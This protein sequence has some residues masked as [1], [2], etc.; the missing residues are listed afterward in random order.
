[1]LIRRK[2]SWEIPEHRASGEDLFRNRRR[3]VQAAAGG[4]AVA[5]AGSLWAGRSHAQQGPPAGDPSTGLYPARRRDEFVPAGA[6]TDEAVFV[7]YTNYYEFGSSKEIW[8]QARELP[9]RPWTLRIDGAVERPFELDI[10]DLLARMV[11]EERVYR[12]R[13]VEA[14]SMV[15][16]WTGF[17]LQALV[18][19]AR[20]LSHARYLRIESFHKPELASGQRASWYPWPYVEGLTI[21]EAGNELALLATGAY[22]K[23]FAQQNGSPLRLVVPWKYGFKSIK[24]IVRITFTDEQPATF[25]ETVQGREYGFWANVNPEVAHPRWSQATEK[26][27]KSTSDVGFFARPEVKP[28]LPYNGYGEQVAHLYRGL[29]ERVGDRLYR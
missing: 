15:V 8:Q 24:G 5:A 21:D 20:P 12:L 25:W 29:Q 11:L 22:G 19:L 10:D 1:M 13:C 23:P 4:I 26:F 14:W 28:T 6:V 16:P 2:R 7:T 17:P 27:L 18:T 9:I 3:L